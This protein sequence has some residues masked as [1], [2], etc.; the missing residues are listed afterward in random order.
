MAHRRIGNSNFLGDWERSET[1]L[2]EGDWKVIRNCDAKK[3]TK[4]GLCN[5]PE[6]FFQKKVFQ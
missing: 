6:K 3:K 1:F 4:P 5:T 2:F